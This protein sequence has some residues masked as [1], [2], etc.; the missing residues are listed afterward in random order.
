MGIQL[1]CD[2]CLPGIFIDGEG[3]DHF[4]INLDRIVSIRIDSSVKAICYDNMLK[5]AR[6]KILH[7]ERLEM[8]FGGQ[9]GGRDAKFIVLDC[10]SHIGEL[11]TRRGQPRIAFDL[12]IFL[13]H[14]GILGACIDSEGGGFCG[15]FPVPFFRGSLFFKDLV[16]AF[17]TIYR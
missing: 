11:T 4:F 3:V 17:Q 16:L 14:I 10:L 13:R 8:A 12:L 1:A 7:D 9:F 15:H 6:C 5:A 2:F